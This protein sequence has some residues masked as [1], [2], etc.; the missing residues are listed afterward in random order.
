MDLLNN[1]GHRPIE[2]ELDG[3]ATV[4]LKADGTVTAVGKE[5][6]SGMWTKVAEWRD[7][8]A[9]SRGQDHLVGLKNDGTVVATG[10]N[11]FHQ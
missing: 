4:C 6:C 5:C 7:I 2:F 8:I 9:I 10:D 11:R 1:G 3:L